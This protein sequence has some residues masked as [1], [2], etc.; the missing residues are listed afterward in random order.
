MTH[1]LLDLAAYP[2][3]QDPL[4][5]E[6]GTVLRQFGGWKKQALNHMKK[7]NSVLRESQRMNGVAIGR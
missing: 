1:I 7:L 2:E 3:Y 4:K 5:K 6:I